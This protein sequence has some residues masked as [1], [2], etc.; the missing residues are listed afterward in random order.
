VF[1]TG[2]GDMKDKG[3][4]RL[5]HEGLVGRVIGGYF[6]LS[7]EIER[8]I[9][10]NRIEAYNLPEGVMTQ[11]YRAIG[12]A[13]DT[14]RGPLGRRVHSIVNYERFTC[15]DDVFDEYVDLV[16]RVGQTCDL[17][18]KRYTSGAFLRHKLGSELAK[19]EIS[20]AVL[21]PERNVRR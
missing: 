20:S 4:N 16:K 11:L 17:S 3:L 12:D 5:A 7:P 6:G 2:Q 19:R 15:D 13:V 10:D 1:S 14:L 18:A 21:N 9:V 8:L